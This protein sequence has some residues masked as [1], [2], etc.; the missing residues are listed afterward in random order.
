MRRTLLLLILLLPGCGYTDP[1]KNPDP[2]EVSGSVTKAGK[3][4]SD[5]V[6]NFQPT[7]VG[8]QAAIPVKGGA[9]RGSI[10]PG[11]YTYY[12]S[13]VSGKATAF[14]AIPEKYREGSLERQ[15]E[16]EGGKSLDLTLD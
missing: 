3:P 1:G 11:K 16:I 8:T 2:V 7:G 12:L 14:A 4:I 10:T 5:V 6:L 15:V 13:E 9:Y